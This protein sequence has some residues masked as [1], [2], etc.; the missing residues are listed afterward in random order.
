M[1]IYILCK[2]VDNY[3]DIGFVYRLAKAIYA[4]DKNLRLRLVV[5]G[6]DAFSKLEPRID[7]GQL[8]QKLDML[9]V[10]SWNMP[11]NNGSPEAYFLDPPLFVLEC[12]AC[13]RPDW[14]EA[15]L[16]D[17]KNY[18]ANGQPKYRHIIN[19]EYLTAESYAEEFHLMPSL[20]RSEYVKKHFFM[21]GFTDK[22]GS[23][24]AASCSETQKN[25]GIKSP[26]LSDRMELLNSLSPGIGIADKAGVIKKACNSF[27]ITLFTYEM[28]YN[29]II[30]ALEEFSKTREVLVFAAS[31]LS[32]SCFTKAWQKNNNAFTVVFLPFLPQSLWDMLLNCSDFALVRG[33]DSW[34]RAV[35][36]GKLFVWQAYVQ[37]DNY[38]L[39][40]VKAFLN[41][42]KNFNNSIKD[43]VDE[44]AFNT[45][46]QLTLAINSN[47]DPSLIS[48]QSGLL[49][50]F[51]KNYR[52]W[53]P[54]FTKLSKK[55]AENGSLEQKLLAFLQKLAV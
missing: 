32:Q 43:G 48:R 26:C 19:I 29:P 25:D 31:G 9:E 35:L 36:A 14:L 50:D 55:I 24:I 6:L 54:F 10:Y 23:L 28:D 2:V 42:I 51:L 40:K 1:L 8:Y 13:G 44:G 37:D 46:V 17:D 16:F 34:A 49:L 18:E 3:G 22:T 4:C 47:D 33:E 20:T 27:W 45:F 15:I 30:K 38:Q 41:F 12:F 7:P 21:P 53:Q 52:K 11:E 5:D 39:V